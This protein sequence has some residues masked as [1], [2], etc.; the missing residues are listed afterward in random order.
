MNKRSKKSESYSNGFPPAVAAK[1]DLNAAIKS[2]NKSPF[3]PT[4]SD[5]G[6]LKRQVFLLENKDVSN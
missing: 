2:S 6:S 1:Q 5:Q 4:E 3:C